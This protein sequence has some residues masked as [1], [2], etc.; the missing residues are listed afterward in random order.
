MRKSPKLLLFL[1]FA[2][3]LIFLVSCGT[4]TPQ[5]PAT[6]Q[7]QGA[8]ITGVTFENMTVTYDGT[9]KEL[10]AANLPAGVSAVYQNNKATDAGVY[11]ATVTLSG[12]GYKT[13]TMQATLTVEK[14][15]ISGVSLSQNEEITMDTDRHFP[16]I[17]GSLPNGATISWYFNDVL[18]NEGVKDPDTYAVRA[19]ISAKNY[20][21]LTL[22]ASFKIKA[23]FVGF[24]QN[25]VNAFG[26]VPDTWDILPDSFQVDNYV[27]RPSDIPT[28][29]NFTNVS[30]IPQKYIGKQLNVALG[31]LNKCDSA[32]DYVNIVHGS[33]NVIANAYQTFLNTSPDNYKEFSDN[34]GSFTY[35]IRLDGDT[36]YIHAQIGT[37]AV[38]LYANSDDASYGARIQL[39]ATTVL[40]YTVTQDGFKVALNVL[41]ASSTQIEFVRDAQNPA[42]V[43]GYLYEYLSVA[44]KEIVA[45][46]ALLHVGETYTTVV[47]T[48]G[49]FIP[50]SDS[51]NCEVYNN[52]TGSLVGT[53]VKESLGKVDVTFDTLWYNLKDIDG[54]VSI[55]KEDKQ[56]GL[57]PDKI[58]I[59][60][61]SDTIHTMLTS[62]S[63]SAS[64]RFDI[65][66]K[67][68]IAYTYDATTEE[69]TQ[70][71]FEVPMIFI[72]ED[73]LDTFEAD[74]KSKNDVTVDV[75]V[76]V[77][78]QNA[79]YQ[80]YH[81]LVDA[82]DLI[83]NLVQ[84][85]DITSYCAQD[86]Q[87]A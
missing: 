69:Y 63:L 29:T 13:K 67:T 20:H 16:T 28:Y 81:V 19:V 25:I 4:E 43:T 5:G 1:V 24:A 37:V 61:N 68:V 51:R 8:E 42:I 26:N 52:A 48:K 15:T 27:I 84:Q 60:A 49:D 46:S 2:L 70:V 40:K 58:Y 44:G 56:N 71:E 64:R 3:A 80:G 85:S 32:L 83:K 34:T 30:S 38:T 87:I 14:A 11:Q 45:T 78:D 76:T 47:G 12:Q 79:V 62:I 55:K 7:D 54:I 36:Y 82:Y 23:N 57:N 73:Y 53:E 75:D 17:A 22:T 9:Q 74:F 18:V 31:L 33:L 59:N 6:P 39:T 50:T 35:T 66:F 77:A 72:Q 21:D 86:F 10:T 65:E 41:D